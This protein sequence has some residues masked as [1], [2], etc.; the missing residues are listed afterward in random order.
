MPVSLNNSKNRVG[1]NRRMRH[2]D[3]MDAVDVSESVLEPE[4]EQ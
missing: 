4:P 3:V 1:F 2:H